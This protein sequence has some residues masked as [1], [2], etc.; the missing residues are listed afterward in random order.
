MRISFLPPDVSLLLA[1]NPQI[2]PCSYDTLS[3]LGIDQT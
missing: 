2:F 1:E 3:I